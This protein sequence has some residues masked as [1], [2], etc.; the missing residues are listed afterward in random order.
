ME[1]DE[2]LLDENPKDGYIEIKPQIMGVIS[3]G[4]RYKAMIVTNYLYYTC[5]TKDDWLSCSIAKDANLLYFSTSTNDTGKERKGHITVSATDS[6]GKVLKSTVFTVEQQIPEKTEE[7]VTASPS[8]LQFDAE[9]GKKESVIDH[10]YAFNYLDVDWSDELSGWATIDWKETA[11]GWN[12]VVDANANNTG[13]ER[14][15][16]ITIY[17]G[18]SNEAIQDAKNGKFDP[19]VVAKTTI[20][21]KQNAEA[22]FD[23]RADVQSCSFKIYDFRGMNAEGK[24]VNTLTWNGINVLRFGSFESSGFSSEVGNFTC[25]ANGNRGAF[26]VTGE[27][28]STN[29]GVSKE[30]FKFT[31]EPQENGNYGK[32]SD[33][34]YTRYQHFSNG[35]GNSVLSNTTHTWNYKI[36]LSNIPIGYVSKDNTYCCWSGGY[37]DGVQCLEFETTYSI[38]DD[39][40][41]KNVLEYACNNY[42][43]YDLTNFYIYVFFPE[44]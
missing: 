37:G 21:V 7:W 28:E 3:N 40:E 43:D 4:S 12:I 22:P 18:A 5:T 26:T 38:Y 33:L 32:I 1:F 15:G 6:K 20:L 13:E 30:T 14:S 8:T 42:A 11:T 36:H 23:A 29:N 35:D 25:T 41:Q 27:R 39:K 19:D 34:V 31:V 10:S 16:T 2:I 17:A 44:K 9:G 24:E